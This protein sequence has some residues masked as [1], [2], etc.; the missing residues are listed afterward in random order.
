MNRM[1][2]IIAGVGAAVLASCGLFG[3]TAPRPVFDVASIKP[4]APDDK[5]GW[6]HFLPGGRFQVINAQLIFVIQQLYGVKDYQIVG[7][8]KWIV[9]WSTARFNIEAKAEGVTN[10]DQL[11]LMAKNLLEDRFQLKL[12]R[13]TRDLPVYVLTQGKNGMKTKATPDSGKPIRSG[14]VEPVAPG[15]L[16][17]ADITMEAFIRMLSRYAD[18]PVL[19][20]TN[21]TQ[22]FTFKLQWAEEERP[23]RAASPDDAPDTSRP[24]LF[25][26]IQEQMGLK[27][28]PQKAPVEVLVIDHVEKPSEN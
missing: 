25:T 15:W 13:E 28:V 20:G 10:Q 3:Q 27:L 11:R 6:V 26:A 24:S 1:K 19:D 7:A 16:Q 8:P 22:K 23:G 9:D 4:S 18:R 21:Y 5:G 2:G 17:G 12:H 14:F